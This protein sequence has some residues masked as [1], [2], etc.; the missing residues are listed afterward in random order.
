MQEY[1]VL[2]NNEDMDIVVARCNKRELEELLAR[3]PELA[4]EDKYRTYEVKRVRP[5]VTTMVNVP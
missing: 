4:N 1:V 3:K 5:Q 2:Y